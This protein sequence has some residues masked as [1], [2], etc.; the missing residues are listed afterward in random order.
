MPKLDVSWQERQEVIKELV[1]RRR[2]L[3][4]EDL[5][6]LLAKRG[7]H[8]TQSSLSR[9]LKEL[10][11]IKVDGCYRLA[12]A[13]DAGDS[14]PGWG[15]MASLVR[16][17]RPAGPNLLV[18]KSTPGAASVLGLLIDKAGWPEVVGTVAGDDTLF[19][20]TASRRDQQSVET[21]LS[22]LVGARIDG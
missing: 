17:A 7:F 22:H 4:Q 11:A 12:E 13:I 16:G 9:D 14:T 15:R 1:S 8:T 18:I 2:V 21:R 10:R 6:A 20:A 5:L 3:S 19:L